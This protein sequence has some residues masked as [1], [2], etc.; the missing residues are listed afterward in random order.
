M[1]ELK[2][3]IIEPKPT[4]FTIEVEAMVPTILKY[5]ILAKSPEEAL[6]NLYKAQPVQ[7]PKLSF[8]GM[9]KLS[10]KVFNYGTQI[11]KYSKRF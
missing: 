11:L 9:K 6:S 1:E 7:T 8:G 5:K 10:A 2:K 3:K 4:Y